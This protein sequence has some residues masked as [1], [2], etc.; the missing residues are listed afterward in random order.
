MSTTDKH[1]NRLITLLKELFQLD[2]PELDFGLYKIM[3]AKS[4]Q[5]TK[6]L[7]SDLLKE[8]E[9]AFGEKDSADA[10]QMKAQAVARLKESLGDEAL[11]DKG[12][13][14]EAFRKLP[15]GK[16]Y[17]EEMASAEAAKDTLNAESEIYDHLY[18]FFERYYDNGD[19]MSRRYYARESDA[20]AAPFSVPYD[21]REVYLHWANKD[22][23]YIKSSEYLSNYTFEL[24]EAIRQEAE[25]Q[26][27]LKGKGQG[28]DFGAIISDKPLK[29]HCRI[30]EASEG[31][32]GNIKAASDQK[33][34]F[35]IHAD[36]P[37]DWLPLPP[38]EGWGE[39]KSPELIINFQYR[40]DSEKTGQDNTWQQV[41]LQ[42][43]EAAI[44]QVLNSIGQ[45]DKSAAAFL[46]GLQLPAPTDSKDKRTLLGK[47]LQKYAA[48]NSMD[49][50]IHKDL[51]GFMRREL[52]FYI[53][54]EIMRLDDIENAEAPKVEQYLS[55]I[56]VLRR[57]AHQL[58]AFLAQLED[59]QK[60]LWLKKKFVT[61]THY[62]ITLDRVPEKFYG[63]IAANEKQFAEW[64]KLFA[65][66]EIK[67]DLF[68]AAAKSAV[69]PAQAGIQNV[70]FLKANPYLL[71]DTA[72]FSGDFK[73]RLLAEIPD[74]DA[75]CDGVLIH[76]ENFQ[77]LG[78]MQE[79]YREQVKCIYIDPPYN[80]DAGP[81]L[82]KNGYKSSSW[83]S[84]MY[85]RLAESKAV[86][87][88]DG[89]LVA[90]IDDEQQRE[91][92]QL[93]SSIFD[94][95]LLGTICVRSNPSGRPTKSGYAVSH[96]YL[97]FAGNSSKSSISRL[98]PTDEQMSRFNE[99]DSEGVFEWRNLRREGSNSD[100]SARRALYYPIYINGDKIR[101]PLLEWNEIEEEWIV[102][103]DHSAKEKVVW[104]N[105]DSEDQKTWRWEWKT[106][107]CSLQ[108][109]AVRKD[110][111]GKDY[112]YYKRRPNEDG[113]VSVSSWFDAKYSAT[114]HGTALLKSLFVKSPFSY[115]KSIFAV[116]DSI[117]VGGGA[118]NDSIIL[119]YF[120]GS[121]TSAHATIFL[122]R[123]D[124]GHRKYLLV[125]QNDY[126]DT[127]LKP[128]IQKVV[129]S[130]DWKEGKPVSREGISHCFKYL[131]LESYE[132]ALNNLVLKTDTSRDAALEKNP[133]LQ[134]DYLLNYFLD[135][136][137]SG[138]QSLLN[139]ADFRDPT[140]Y[141]MQIKKPGSEEQ[142]LQSIDLIETFN[143]LIGLWVRHIA[144]PQS[145][146]AEFEREQ[147]ADLP[148]AK[149]EAHQNTRLL[150]T[151][152]KPDASGVYWFR[153]IEGYTLKV[154]GDDTSKVPTLIVWRKQ[155]D[156]AEKD[157][158]VLQK[159]LMEKLQISPREQT[160]GVIYINGS[161][162]LPNPVVEGEQTRVR[163]IEEA[164]HTAMW[165]GDSV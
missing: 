11:D 91:L 65:I 121:G 24:N 101:V 66:S 95:N 32:H 120:G 60:K 71:L 137:T 104:P 138:S 122:N 140:V 103:E 93:L 92:S 141:R 47:Y 133:K 7:E 54:N 86:M 99:S 106:V 59:F 51:G 26:K 81:I 5:I 20:R 107:M 152:L 18:R 151:R 28:F 146:S 113:V 25:R 123:Q 97:L 134:R 100:R 159:F 33:R 80:T 143:W 83:V 82:Y 6:F 10:S 36:K 52:D 117:Y 88:D 55:K 125:E 153:L 67:T 119:D 72:L 70:E 4:V 77:A 162:T 157:N 127:V 74:L 38:G 30:V 42:Q 27:G 63:E 90:A 110:R 139:I 85:D 156:D 148:P 69:I 150:C 154:P 21:G 164:F 53:K 57:I 160:Y 98:P 149:N 76:S 131:R 115:P 14:Q 61:E 23:Y 44:L 135:V 64:E 50:F 108:K 49:Y 58:I 75:Q 114:E 112:I 145:F 144:A 102:Q 109:L 19:F 1:R 3:H 126:F 56:R 94:D 29:V 68:T 15:A 87:K 163:L 73:Q 17:L 111:S 2:Q 89:V 31:E 161:H 41:R 16:K 13:L 9:Q 84:L 142:T 46:Q 34:F 48:R 8:I 118:K 45:A 130:K 165:A 116:I 105:N 22:Q 136:E 155:T 12:N 147:D 96:E 124:R 129:Y 40:T 128:R 78:L 79:K 43:A 35:I 158:A 37:I 132:D 39:G 62:C